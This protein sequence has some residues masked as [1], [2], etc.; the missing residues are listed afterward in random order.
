[1]QGALRRAPQTSKYFF[2]NNALRGPQENST[3]ILGIMLVFALL[4]FLNSNLDRLSLLK[5][6][7]LLK[8]APVLALAWGGGQLEV[9]VPF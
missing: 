9:S 6:N 3:L 7:T 8:E 2:L 5:L 4:P 1:M